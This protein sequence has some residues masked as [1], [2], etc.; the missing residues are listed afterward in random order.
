MTRIAV[1]S[2][3]HGNIPAL[4]AVLDDLVGRDVDEVLHGGD[5]V[6]RGPEGGAVVRRVRALGLRGVRGNHE[7]LLLDLRCGRVDPAWL[8]SPDWV[9]SR[10][11]AAEL[12]ADEAAWIERLPDDLVTAA[13]HGLPGLRIVH[14][15]PRGNRDGIGAWTSEE[16]LREITDLVSE[17]LLVCA[18][19]HR[20]MDRELDGTRVVNVGSVG[21][22]FNGDP[23]AHYAI[24]EW[25]GGAWQVEPIR[26]PYERE[27]TRARYRE[28]GFLAAGGVV[29]QLL[30]VEL[31][32][33]R[34][35]LVPFQSWCGALGRAQDEASL[36]TFLERYE[37]GT[38]LRAFLAAERAAREPRRGR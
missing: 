27:R 5:L 18:H 20:P 21:L 4:E 10:W 7:D 26:V 12:A 28:T 6:G 2:D 11:M 16:S 32:T 36:A 19:T 35:H 29:A 1:L 23:R 34:S 25:Q 17:P 15:S 9:C 38:S 14:G 31:E 22:P 30:A 24:F 33:A 37:P 3:V 8:V 13:A